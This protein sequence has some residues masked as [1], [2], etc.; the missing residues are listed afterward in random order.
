MRRL[1]SGFLLCLLLA[2]PFAGQTNEWKRYKNTDGNFSVL[3]PGESREGPGEALRDG[4]EVHSVLV[5]A[6]PAV[7][8]VTY[9]IYHSAQ[10]VDDANFQMYKRAYFERLPKCEPSGGAPASPAIAGY[11]G[12]SYRGTFETPNNKVNIVVNLYWGKR[13]SFAV[14]AMFPSSEVEPAAKVKKFLESFAI[15]DPAK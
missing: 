5:Q 1:A 4:L 9:G 11:I 7:Y 14:Q 15:I 3:F 8:L 2:I 6:S 12:R 13:H 10:P